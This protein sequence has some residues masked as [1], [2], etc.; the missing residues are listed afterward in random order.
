[1]KKQIARL[2]GH[3]RR[4]IDLSPFVSLATTDAEHHLEASPRGGPL[5]FVKVT[6]AGDLLLPDAPGNN[7]LD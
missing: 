4:F 2:D 1:M 3:C 7:R 5:G 6:E